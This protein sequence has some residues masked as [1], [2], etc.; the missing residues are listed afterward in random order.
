MAFHQFFNL[1]RRRTATGRRQIG[2]MALN[3][4]LYQTC[5]LFDVGQMRFDLR[6]TAL[7]LFP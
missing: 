6:K 1:G 2:W 7:T 4:R 5:A 3:L